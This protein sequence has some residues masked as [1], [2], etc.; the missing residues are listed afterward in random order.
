MYRRSSRYTM[1]PT[2]SFTAP[3]IISR[4]ASAT[5]RTRCL[6]SDSS[7]APTLQRHL[8]SPGSGAARL[9]PSASR[10]FPCPGPRR[11][12]GCILPHSSQQNRA[13]NRCPLARRQGFLHCQPLFSTTL[14]LGPPATAKHRPDLTSRPL[15]LRPGG[16]P[17]EH[18]NCII[19][20]QASTTP[21]P[22]PT[23][24]LHMRMGGH[25]THVLFQLSANLKY[26]Y[27]TLLPLSLFERYV[28]L[29]HSF[30]FLQKFV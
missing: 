22:P 27:S 13:G 7:P 6:P 5:R 21:P 1:A 15:S 11:P 3:C 8:R 26:M 16:S 18:H 28:C 12:V 23:T 24:L 10:I 2:P 17:V 29:P 30:L 20:S 4:C 9:P 19:P 14:P 25:L